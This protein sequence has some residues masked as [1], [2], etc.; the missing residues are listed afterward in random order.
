LSSGK[1]SRTQVDAA[2][3]ISG[4]CDSRFAPVR[5]AFARNFTAHGEVG[6]ACAVWHDGALAVDLWGGYA[7]SARTQP[8]QAGTLVCCMSVSKAVTALACAALLGRAGGLDLAAP[9]TRY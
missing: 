5:D 9:V 4:A 7:D 3:A 1:E 2:P 6:A 8:W